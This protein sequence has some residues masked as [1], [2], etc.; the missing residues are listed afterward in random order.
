MAADDPSL[1][2]ISTI[3]A[4]V[5]TAAQRTENGME[6]RRTLVDRYARP[7][8]RT[9]RKRGLR[10]DRIED[11]AQEFMLRFIQGEYLEGYDASK[12]R[13]RTWLKACLRLFVA[14]QLEREAYR[15][16]QPLDAVQE[17]SVIDPV[18]ERFETEWARDV[19]NRVLKEVRQR[20]AS[21]PRVRVVWTWD[22]QSDAAARMTHAEAASK[23]GIPLAEFRTALYRGREVQGVV[24]RE[25]LREGI[26][27]PRDIE[28]E[29]SYFISVINR[30]LLPRE[31][32]ESPTP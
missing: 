24:I 15:Q 16:G 14:Q 7:V 10:R 19:W 20:L 25:V 6:A 27:D 32:G 3:L 29:V 31:N 8:V 5:V 13:F 17:P 2:G 1:G 4:L 11:L 12:G 23:F 18:G 28:A 22:S 21:E 26:E 9:L 30:D